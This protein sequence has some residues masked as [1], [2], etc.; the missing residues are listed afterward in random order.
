[1]ALSIDEAARRHAA[2]YLKVLRSANDQLERGDDEA[3]LRLF[4]RDRDQIMH[5]FSWAADNASRIEDA[6][7]LCSAYPYDGEL[8]VYLRLP[9]QTRI[10]WS[11]QAAEAAALIDDDGA[12]AA[13]LHKLA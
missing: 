13:H 10:G 4:D 7:R 9:A 6:A 5:G 3:G 1:M 11:S 12:R 8:I 2:Y